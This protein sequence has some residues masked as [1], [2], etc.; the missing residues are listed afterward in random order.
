MNSRNLIFRLF[1]FAVILLVSAAS[2]AFALEPQTL[3]N[4][5][6]SLGTVIGN[7]AEGP[8]GNLYGTTAQGGVG[9][10]GTIFRVVLAPQFAGIAK[11]PDQRLA[12]TA[13]GPSGSPLR[14]WTAPDLAT[15]P[16]SWTVLT[17]STFDQNGTFFYTDS[18]PA[19]VRVLYRVSSP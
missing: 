19:A 3:F 16:Q 1:S 5:S 13:T 10:G 7:L 14:L 17:N 6:V 8:D 15:L 9:G 4:L 18:P 12:L 2:P 11:L